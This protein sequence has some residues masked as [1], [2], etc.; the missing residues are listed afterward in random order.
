VAAGTLPDITGELGE[1]T[2]QG[3]ADKVVLT[4][5]VCN[6]GLKAVGANLPATFYLGD[7]ADGNILCIAYTAEPV[8][9]GECREVS[10]E[11][12]ISV[13]GDVTVVVDDDGM[14]GQ[15]ALECFEN[16]NTDTISI[17]NCVPPG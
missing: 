9:I 5:T 17:R 2:C 1:Q 8:P 7:P 12:D 11:I 6:R 16:N 15:A 10:C 13:D 14:G 3:V 4:S